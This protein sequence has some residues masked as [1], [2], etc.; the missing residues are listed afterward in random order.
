[1]LGVDT[2]DSKK[3]GHDADHR[4]IS[5][6]QDAAAIEDARRSSELEGSRSTDATRVDQDAYVRGEIDV[7]QL[8]SGCARAVRAGVITSGPLDRRGPRVALAGL[9]DPGS[10]VLRNKVGA[11]TV[12]ELRDAENDLVETRLAQLRA[13]PSLVARTYDLTH[14]NWP[15]SSSSRTS[16]NG[17]G[18]CARSDWRRVKE[19]TR[20]SC[21]RSRS[22]VPWSTWR[23]ESLRRRSC[24][25][26]PR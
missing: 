5:A 24:G 10:P 20:H 18:S 9:P 17:L 12:E 3:E 6:K 4:N 8:V 2:M 16:S 25:R 1:M 15:I 7:E 13:R 21:H 23:V 26:H 19:P 22:N 14:L 11:T